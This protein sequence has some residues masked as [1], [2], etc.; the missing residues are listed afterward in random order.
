MSQIVEVVPWAAASFCGFMLS[1]INL[2]YF[3]SF[4]SFFSLNAMFYFLFSTNNLCNSHITW[5]FSKLCFHIRN[6]FLPIDFVWSDRLERIFYILYLV[7][8]IW[9]WL[10]NH[11]YTVTNKTIVSINTSQPLHISIQ[12]FYKFFFVQ[13]KSTWLESYQKDSFHS[14]NLIQKW[15]FRKLVESGKEQIPSCSRVPFEKCISQKTILVPQLIQVIREHSGQTQRHNL[16]RNKII[17][18]DMEVSR[19][20]SEGMDEQDDPLFCSS[21]EDS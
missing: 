17:W 12:I 18:V 3:F 7:I 16:E 13:Q 10:Y 8:I 14:F 11:I 15:G 1:K 4:F 21:L 19:K 5:K 9:I 20:V 6:H 2:F